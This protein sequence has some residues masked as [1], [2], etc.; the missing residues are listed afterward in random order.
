MQTPKTRK[1]PP[2]V[3]SSKPSAGVKAPAAL[4]QKNEA[5][6]R[7]H[8]KVREGSRRI[9]RSTMAAALQFLA[10]RYEPAPLT[11][12]D[13]WLAYADAMITGRKGFAK[14]T[15]F[16]DQ[17]PTKA[18]LEGAVGVTSARDK[19]ALAD[20]VTRLDEV[21]AQLSHVATPDGATPRK[22]FRPT[23]GSRY[24]G[25]DAEADTP[26]RPTNVSVTRFAQHD[27]S[28]KVSGIPGT[29]SVR[30]LQAGE[31]GPDTRVLIYLH[32]LGSRAEEAEHVAAELLS[33]GDYAVIS[34]DLP[35]HGC[36]TRP[37]HAVRE[38]GLKYGE[39]G[40]PPQGFP[41]LE[42]MERFVAAF[43]DQLASRHAG[44]VDQ[45]K[46]V[47]G[48]SLGGTLAMRLSMDGSAF[49][50]RSVA[51]WSPA[52]LWGSFN[53]DSF[54]REHV[55]DDLLRKTTAPDFADAQSDVPF[56]RKLYFDFNFVDAPWPVSTRNCVRWWSAAF[57]THY[58]GA[59]IDAAIA[60]RLETYGESMRQ[61]Q[62]RLAYEQL[63]FS[64]HDTK[65]KRLIG[66]EAGARPVLILCGEK[67]NDLGATIYDNS[68]ALEKYLREDKKQVGRAVWIEDGGHSIHDECPHVLAEELHAFMVENGL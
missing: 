42:K 36:T 15:A 31:I 50:P 26:Y 10:K 49:E 52:G 11:R 46:M 61:W 9:A 45:L 32:G 51:F 22:A 63:C 2:F 12:R 68:Q 24:I 19:R 60:D 47:I 40:N 41:Y 64:I 57:L 13:Q 67:D 58:D 17:N 18:A 6:P 48:G 25:I 3:G 44:F 53:A 28:M 29:M 66:G 7:P 39:S 62:F 5:F 54:K 23:L 14:W 20:I 34:P 43:V 1:A 35:G 59:P 33:L 55:T 56:G 27:L 37:P 21:S 16:R 4:T 38:L 65:T 30:Y 8:P